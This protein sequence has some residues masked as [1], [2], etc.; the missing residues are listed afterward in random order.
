MVRRLL[1]LPAWPVLCVVLL[2]M[3][4]SVALAGVEY[5]G[6]L[7][8]FSTP[9]G[10]QTSG[11]WRTQGFDVI[12]WNV[13]QN[14]NGTWHYVYGRTTSVLD[15]VHFIIQLPNGATAADLLNPTGAFSSFTVGTFTPSA[16][17]PFLPASIYGADFRILPGA[18]SRVAFD[19]NIEP[20]FGNFYAQGSE[21]ESAFNDGFL[22][23]NTHHD[24]ACGS[25]DHKI[26]V[27]D[28]TAK[29]VPDASTI[30][31]VCF[32]SLQLLAVRKKLFR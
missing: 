25:I 24:P 23:P 18:D 6:A 30:V 26:L 4:S 27:P 8:S 7:T 19:A 29:P 20:N 28:T 32:G 31:L 22:I 3:V 12:G 11:A 9:A 2:Y 13:T 16:T 5:S 21:L 17:L 15:T 14:A 1:K 10:L